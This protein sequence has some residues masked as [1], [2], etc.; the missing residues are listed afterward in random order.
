MPTLYPEGDNYHSSWQFVTLLEK[1]MQHSCY[2][3]KNSSIEK[4]ERE[5]GV[6]THFASSECGDWGFATV[7]I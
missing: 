6:G 4:N 3:F 2:Y 1:I 7:W 5:Y